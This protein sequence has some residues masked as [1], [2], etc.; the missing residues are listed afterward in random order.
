M[1]QHQALL[2]ESV[3][4]AQASLNSSDKSH[5]ERRAHRRGGSHHHSIG[6]PVGLIGGMVGGLFARR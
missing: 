2:T 4:N 1:P 6:G 5:R 3:S